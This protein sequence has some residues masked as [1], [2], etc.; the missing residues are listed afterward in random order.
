MNALAFCPLKPGHELGVKVYT[1]PPAYNASV[2]YHDGTANH[3]GTAQ[4]FWCTA[5]SKEHEIG[6]TGEAPGTL[7]GLCDRA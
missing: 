2:S 3:S 1:V 4:A 7:A 5:C 6:I